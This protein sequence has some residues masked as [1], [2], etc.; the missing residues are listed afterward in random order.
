MSSSKLQIGFTTVLIAAMLVGV[1]AHRGWPQ[2]PTA[3]RVVRDRY[4]A[5]IR[6]DVTAKKLALVFTGDKRGEST[7][8][9]LD[10]LKERKVKAGFFVTG[11]FVRDDTLKSLVKRAVA[12]GHYVGPHSDSHP[13]YCSW[14]ERE[15]TLVSETSFKTDLQKNIEALKT[16]GGFRGRM[17]RLFIAPYEWYNADQVRWSRE[18]GV[19]LI[20][21]TPGS[22]SNR[23]YA[24]EGDQ[25]FVPSRRIFDDIL[26]YDKKDSHGLN[27]FILLL[28]LGSGRRDPFH[29]LL[30]LLCD[31][32]ARRGYEFVRV[33]EMVGG[34]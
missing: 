19:T 4:G 11:N 3:E 17:P 14:D 1:H 30:G 6:G 13:L 15:K 2:A 26:A 34:E 12:E 16:L 9:I 8:A 7:S 28:H 29:P 22:G 10:A 24:P 21:F 27:G 23:D 32:L 20:N 5:V 18:M 33:D 25:R 31:E